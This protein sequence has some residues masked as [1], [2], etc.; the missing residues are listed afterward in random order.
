M[1]VEVLQPS[2]QDGLGHRVAAQAAQGAF[3]TQDARP[4]I[5][6]RRNRLTAVETLLLRFRFFSHC[7]EVPV[8]VRSKW[9]P[10]LHISDSLRKG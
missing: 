7:V 4:V 2:S 8:G 3:L 5:A 10:K 1:Q 6:T 9:T